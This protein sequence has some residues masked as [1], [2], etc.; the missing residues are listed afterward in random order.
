MTNRDLLTTIEAS[1]LCG[2]SP[3]K[4]RRLIEMGRLPAKNT[5][6]GKRPRYAIRRVDL[7]AFFEPDNVRPEARRTAPARRKRIDAD[8]PHVF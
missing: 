1:S 4:I 5:S 2:M 8:V 3:A 6:T 7:D